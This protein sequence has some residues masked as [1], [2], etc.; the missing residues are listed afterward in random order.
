M[1][2]VLFDDLLH[3]SVSVNLITLG[4]HLLRRWCFEDV[5]RKLCSKIII[6]YC[7]VRKTFS[8]HIIFSRKDY[9]RRSSSEKMNKNLFLCEKVCFVKTR[10]ERCIQ[11]GMFTP[12]SRMVLRDW[13]SNLSTKLNITFWLRQ[14]FSTVFRFW[15]LLPKSNKLQFCCFTFG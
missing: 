10:C 2:K 12:H 4:Y 5:F 11:A 1:M 3:R 13:T 7:F 9:L 6:I 14:R 15:K 8:V